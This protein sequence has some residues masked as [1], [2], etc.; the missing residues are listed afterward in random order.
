MSSAGH[1]Y[2]APPRST[3]EKASTD[4]WHAALRGPSV[5]N[6]LRMALATLLC[7][8]GYP[9]VVYAMFRP[10]GPGSHES[11]GGAFVYGGILVSL[12]FLLAAAVTWASRWRVTAPRDTARP[13]R[14]GNTA[15][16]T[17]GRRRG[18][19]RSPVPARSQ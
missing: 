11:A 18:S 4:N 5:R 17:D 1:P 10:R 16:A 8:L 12:Y 2:R 15:S 13:G 9:G 7:S 14:R 19:E 6:S 3:V